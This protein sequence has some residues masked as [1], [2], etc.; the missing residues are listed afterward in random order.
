MQHQSSNDDIT[1]LNIDIWNEFILIIQNID[2]LI[3][4]YKNMLDEYN[5][6]NNHKI[7]K[8]KKKLKI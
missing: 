7:K 6:N 2:Q 5:K 8:S 4:Y 1:K 3:E